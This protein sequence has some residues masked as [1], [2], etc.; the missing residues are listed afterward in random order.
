MGGG[1]R[2]PAGFAGAACER[3]RAHRRAHRRDVDNR[4]GQRRLRGGRRR[5][6][7]ESRRGGRSGAAVAAARHV[8]AGGG[9]FRGDGVS[10]RPRSGG[11]ARCAAPWRRTRPAVRVA[12]MSPF[13]AVELSAAA[14]GPPAWTISQPNPA[15]PAAARGGRRTAFAVACEI[16]RAC[17]AEAAARPGRRLAVRAAPEALAALEGPLRTAVDAALRGCVARRGGMAARALRGLRRGRPVSAGGTDEGRPRPPLPDSAGAPRFRST[18][19]S[20]RRAAATSISAAGSR[21]FTS[22]PVARRAK[23]ATS[24]R[25]VRTPPAIEELCLHLPAPRRR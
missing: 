14:R 3:R 6:A 1:Y 15:R 12:P 25:R 2:G 4:R 9:R 17:L 20:V 19:L 8:G 10:A 21:V 16:V 5:V 18:A 11:W 7:L 22:S 23:K 13:G 24:K